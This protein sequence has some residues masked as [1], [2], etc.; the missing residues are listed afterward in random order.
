MANETQKII[1][2]THGLANK[3]DAQTLTSWWK[4]SLVEGLNNIGI[5]D[6]QFEFRLAYWANLLYKN[7][8]HSD[9]NFSFDALYNTEPYITAKEGELRKHRDWWFDNAA[10]AA[11]G[12]GGTTVDLLKQHFGMNSLADWVLGKLAKDLAFY[13]DPNQEL[14]DR[15]GNIVKARAAITEVVQS[16][17]RKAH[18]EDKQIMLIGHSMGSVVAYDSLRQL[19]RE[20]GNITVSHFVTIGSPLGLPH[21]KGKIIE[22]RERRYPDDPQVRT[23]TN[24]APTGAISQTAET[25]WRPTCTCATTTSPTSKAWPFVTM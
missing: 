8:L 19:G 6:P 21:V 13:Y 3:S 22:E 11:R 18:A 23:P 9:D 2:G 25:R 20:E 12:I 5:N 10:A 4:A 14:K 24:V 15:N 1:I 16:A 7:P 17:V